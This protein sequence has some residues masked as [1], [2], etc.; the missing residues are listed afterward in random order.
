MKNLKDTV[1]T[2]CGLIGAICG[3]MLVAQEQGVILP[4]WANTV[5]IIAI[6]V[7][8]AIAL[9]LQGKNPNGTRK[10]DNQVES[11]NLNHK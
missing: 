2:I 10:S 7:S 9:F 5:V 3:A 8:G 11:Q 4:T 1:T 6:A